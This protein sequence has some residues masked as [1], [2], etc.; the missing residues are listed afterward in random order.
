MGF[1][2]MNHN[3]K[4]SSKPRVLAMIPARGGS[5]GVARKNIR[6]VAGIPLVAYS[7]NAAQRAST[8]NLLVGSTD[9]SEIREIM[10]NHGCRVLDRPVELAADDTPMVPVIQNVIDQ[11]RV[12]GQEFEI[13]VLLQPTAPLR[14][15]TDIDAAVQQLEES[16]CD[17][18]LSL[19]KVEDNHPSRM[20]TLGEKKQL[21]PVMSEP[22][23]KLRQ[24]F[25]GG[26][27]SKWCNICRAN[28]LFRSD[29]KPY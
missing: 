9:D 14:T 25:A 22:K 5:K 3:D 29:G 17:S 8:V 2:N 23:S 24:S 11:L 19:Y 6:L 13:L 21:Q 26:V 15:S 10:L 20:Y 7:I 1:L 28:S 18:L 16:N 12:E 27:P 4:A